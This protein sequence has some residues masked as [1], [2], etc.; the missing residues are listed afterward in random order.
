MKPSGP[1]IW[2]T[3]LLTGNNTEKRLYELIWKRTIASQM[4][5]ARLEKTTVTIDGFRTEGK[6]HCRR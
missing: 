2:T 6:I 1:L 3:S 5:D 4:S